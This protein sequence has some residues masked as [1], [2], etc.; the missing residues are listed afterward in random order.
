MSST[1]A[2]PKGP[3]TILGVA[4]VDETLIA[5]PNG[6]GDED[7]ID[8]T[9]LAYQW[10]RD[11]QEITGATERTYVVSTEDV[12]AQLAVRFSY[13]DFGGTR[14][15]LTSDPEAPVP[16]AGTPLPTED[17]PYNPFIVLGDAI[18]GE[19]LTARP[20]G[21]FDRNGIDAD[22]RSYQWLRDGVEIDGATGQ[23]YVVTEADAGAAISVI[24]S[25]TDLRGNEKSVTSNPKP[26]VPGDAPE[27]V[28][29]V[30]PDPVPA[31]DPTP[32]PDPAP[33]PDPFDLVGTDA[34]DS[35]T[36]TAGV[37]RINGQEGTDKVYFEGDPSNYILTL[38]PSGMTLSDGG[39][40]GFGTVVLDDVERIEFDAAIAGRQDAFDLAVFG[41]H[42]G[43]DREMLEEIIEVYIA[44]FDRAPDAVGLGFWGT[45][46]ADGTSIEELAALFADQAE[47]RATYPD[48]LSNFA[49]AVQVYTNVLGRTPD[50]DGLRFW[51]QALEDGAVSRD[52][53]I[54]EV[55]GGAKAALKPE[56]GYAFTQQ[57][58]AD[59]AYLEN[60]VDIGAQFAVHKG[61]TNV[62]EAAAVMALFDG[63]LGSLS[64]AVAAIEDY[65]SQAL[66]PDSSAFL[67]PLIGVLEPPF[68]G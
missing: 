61:L 41:G 21:V 30:E 60:K 55:L 9:T 27:P 14:E 22:S 57:Q 40:Y 36:A 56:M 44:Y 3:V 63:S 1:N 4:Y 34:S 7:G 49:F 31:P 23:S 18:V 68:G 52:A 64:E 29:V 53:F 42:A 10:L 45:A 25:Y 20:N 19:K 28:V 67:M 62:T 2:A 13:T 8:Y 58:L 24:Y 37:Q 39:R 12:G 26:L 6:V 50:A 65:H 35:F 33:V 17:G 51:T 59:R 54:L 15:V 16:P 46:V 11:G 32:V 43:L 47:T 38:N 5:R 48:G 66:D